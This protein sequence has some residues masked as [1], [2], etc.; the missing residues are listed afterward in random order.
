M[1]FRATDSEVVKHYRKS[2]HPFGTVVSGD[3]FKRGFI[4]SGTDYTVFTEELG[5]RG[6]DVAFFEPRARYRAASSGA[7]RPDPRDRRRSR[8]QPLRRPDP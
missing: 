3:G 5:M 6:L 2:P 8:R 7:A 4:R 1:L